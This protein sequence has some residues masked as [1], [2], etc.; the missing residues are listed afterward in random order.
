MIDEFVEIPPITQPK[1]SVSIKK[2]PI[3]GQGFKDSPSRKKNH[4][5]KLIEDELNISEIITPHELNEQEKK[6]LYKK[7]NIDDN[8]SPKK[9]NERKLQAQKRK[10]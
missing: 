1:R 4:I 8:E 5:D 7:Y 9:G 2:K 6:M 3:K 10:Y